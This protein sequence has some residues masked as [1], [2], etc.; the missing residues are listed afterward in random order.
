[1]GQR[2]QVSVKGNIFIINLKVLDKHVSKHIL[3]STATGPTGDSRGKLTLGYHFPTYFIPKG[4]LK[5]N[6]AWQHYEL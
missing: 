1:M 6:L 4:R 3:L 5:E 2:F